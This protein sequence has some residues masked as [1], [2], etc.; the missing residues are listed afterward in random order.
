[1]KIG[2]TLCFFLG[3]LL[4]FGNLTVIPEGW[5]L[6]SYFIVAVLFIVGLYLSYGAEL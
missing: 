1:M 3:T 4:M 5:K 6:L 2:A